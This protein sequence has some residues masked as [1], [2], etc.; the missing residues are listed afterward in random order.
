MKKILYL[1][2]TVT[3]GFSMCTVF[4][5]CGSESEDEPVRETTSTT[6]EEHAS[7]ANIYAS[8][9]GDYMDKISERAG[10]MITSGPE[11]DNVEIV[12]SW[13]ASATETSQWTMHAEMN[14][15]NQLVYSDCVYKIISY[16]EE[17]NES[18][19]TVYSEGEGYLEFTEEGELAWTG[20]Q[21]EDCRACIFVQTE[22]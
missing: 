2:L 14:D 18:V 19:E 6:E 13:A 17:G 7:S 4:A 1:L 11:G 5:G 20:A 10:A 12:V 16:D 22:G 15:D 21:D 3:L 9:A 8:M